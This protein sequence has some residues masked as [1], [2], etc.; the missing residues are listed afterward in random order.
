[1]DS[2]KNALR[3]R[4]KVIALQAS[5]GNVSIHPLVFAERKEHMLWF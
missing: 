2:S 4:Q 5:H 1:M 3:K